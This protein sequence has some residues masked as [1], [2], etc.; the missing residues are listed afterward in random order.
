MTAFVAAALALTSLVVIGLLRGLRAPGAAARASTD[1][2]N[3]AVYRDQLAEMDAAFAQGAIDA[4]H[5]AAQRDA[6]R[7]RMAEDL[8]PPRPA[9]NAA[10]GRAGAIALGIAIPLAAALVY[11]WIGNPAALAPAPKPEAAAG[12]ASHSLQG[13]QVAAMV[14]RLAARL[15]QNPDDAEGWNMLAR[16]YGALGRFPDAAKAYEQAV[17]RSRPDAQLLADYADVLAM[18]QGRRFD[19]EPDRL[20]AAALAADPRL[21]KALALAGSSAFARKDYPAA[22]GHWERILEQA[23]PDS[24]MARSLQ[25]SVAQ[26]RSLVGGGAPAVSGTVKLAPALA[27]RASPQDTVFVY[28]RAEGSRMPVAILRKRVADLPLEFR[29]DDTLSMSPQARLS[30][31]REVLVGARVSKTGEAVTRPGDFEASVGP[32]RVGAERV[33]LEIATVAR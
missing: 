17:R 32:V 8:A 16:S 26:A 20:V 19:G 25:A 18:A 33:S 5:H 7:R 1:E 22:I 9:S 11:A 28:A 14:E 12:G 29:L 27:A 4:A 13:A 6:I 23:P 10:P 21:V 3:A 31:Q 30:A 2:L 15:K 24:A